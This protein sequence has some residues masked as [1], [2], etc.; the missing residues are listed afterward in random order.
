MASPGYGVLRVPLLAAQ[1]ET[2]AVCEPV[3]CLGYTEVA[4][5]VTGVGTI[6]GGELTI[7][8]AWWNPATETTYTG[9][10]SAI[11]TVTASDVSGGKQK[12]VPL[13]DSA[14]LWIRTR[15]SDAIV[16]TDQTLSTCLVAV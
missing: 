8:T 2:D 9:T 16:G 11:T 4:I 1:T 12:H 14:Y 6:T 3:N 7:E 13:T 10:W 5:Y 15:I